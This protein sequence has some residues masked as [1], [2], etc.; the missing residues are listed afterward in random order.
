MNISKT[1]II[2]ILFILFIF[3]CNEKPK[4]PVSEY[5]DALIDSYKKGQQ[6]GETANL[7]AVK[8][9]I[10]GYYAANGKYPESLE[11]A[12]EFMGAK[13]DISKYEYDPLT[14]RVSLKK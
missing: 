13:I 11:A 3:A 14:G 4:N 2:I 10:E 6:A 12:E 8:R 5:G 1:T 9:A 7:D